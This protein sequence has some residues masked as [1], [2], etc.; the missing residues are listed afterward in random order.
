MKRSKGYLSFSLA[1]LMCNWAMSDLKGADLLTPTEEHGMLFESVPGLSVNLP[2]KVVIPDGLPW[3]I[4]GKSIK[5]ISLYWGVEDAVSPGIQ[6]D[7]KFGVCG[8]VSGTTENHYH[9]HLGVDIAAASGTAVTPVRAGKVERVGDFGNGW[10]QFVVIS[11]DNSTWT[12]VY[13]HLDIDTKKIY[14][15]LSVTTSTVL[16]TVK[17]LDPT[18]TGDINHLHLGIRAAA[19]SATLSQAGYAGCD[20]TDLKFFVNPLKYL[21]RKGANIVDDNSAS[22]SGSWQC[23]NAVDFY[24][25]TGY[26]ILAGGSSGEAVFKLDAPSDGSYKIYA[27]WTPNSNRTTKA[28]FIISNGTSIVTV[29]KSQQSIPRGAWIELTTMNLVT[30]R[31]LSVTIRNGSSTG[32]LV[33][34]AVLIEKQ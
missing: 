22:H 33:S 8:V 17:N 6:K 5:D 24:Y 18:V 29:T 9:K 34:D 21:S 2:N 10:G 23:S 1:L 28:N 11:H 15:G 30:A 31:Q 4:S 19:Y 12:S 32:Y 7:C 20:W 25:G 27:R 3:P 14:G 26:R 13:G 16:G